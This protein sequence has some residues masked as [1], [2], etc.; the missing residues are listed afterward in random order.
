MSADDRMRIDAATCQNLEILQ[1]KTGEKK[2]SLFAAI[3]QN[4]HGARRAHAVAKACGT[5]GEKDAIEGRL[6]AISFYA[7][8]DAETTKTRETKRS[9]LK[10]APDM[11]RALGR[12]SLKGAGRAIWRQ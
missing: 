8:H 10:H 12:M 9:I 11:A 2:G 7:G 1:N 6:D 5:S 3:R 4:S